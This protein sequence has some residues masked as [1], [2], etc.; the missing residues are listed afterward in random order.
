MSILPIDGF[1]PANGLRLRIVHMPDTI[2]DIPL[3][4]PTEL[5]EEIAGYAPPRA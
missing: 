2:H 1:I 5:A 4:R 3:Q